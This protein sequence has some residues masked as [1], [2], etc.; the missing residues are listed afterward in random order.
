[1]KEILN[2]VLHGKPHVHIGKSGITDAVID[3]ISKHFRNKKIIKV[4]FL[5]MGDYTTM[6]EEI[7]RASCRERV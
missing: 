4:R 1:M 7:G 2:Q 5:S 6:K 3:Q